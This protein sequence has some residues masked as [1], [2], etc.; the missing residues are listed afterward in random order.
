[1]SE[2]ALWRCAEFHAKEEQVVAGQFAWGLQDLQVGRP[3][4]NRLR[5]V[6]EVFCDRLG[7]S[8]VV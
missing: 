4:F 3:D 2:V 7:A 8:L 5:I 6:H 1:M